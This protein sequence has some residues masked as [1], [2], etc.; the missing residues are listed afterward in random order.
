M[1][2]GDLNRLFGALGGD[3][4]SLVTLL[5]TLEYGGPKFILEFSTMVQGNPGHDKAL[6]HFV[7]NSSSIMGFSVKSYIYGK[8]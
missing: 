4:R 1:R 5:R 8:L 6:T 2:S 3:V 7:Y